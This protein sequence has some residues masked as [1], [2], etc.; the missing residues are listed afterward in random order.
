MTLGSALNSLSLSP[1]TAVEDLLSSH[2]LMTVS[3]FPV[4]YTA[5]QKYFRH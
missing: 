3:L 4:S 1:L 5:F 2:V